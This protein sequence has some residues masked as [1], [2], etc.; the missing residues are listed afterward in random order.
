ML[1]RTKIDTQSIQRSTTLLDKQLSPGLVE[2]RD[3]AVI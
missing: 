2:P 3:R 1:D